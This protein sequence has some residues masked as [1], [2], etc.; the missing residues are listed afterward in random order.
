M[1]KTR[2]LVFYEQVASMRKIAYEIADSDGGDIRDDVQELLR[3]IYLFEEGKLG[4]VFAYDDFIALCDGRRGQFYRVPS[5]MDE[6]SRTP[7][8]S[9]FLAADKISVRVYNCIRKTN[10]RIIADVTA[11]SA[12]EWLKVK[13]FGRKSDP[14]SM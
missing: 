6:L 9:S 10:C 12:D 13:S 7:I 1:A 4:L 3:A 11:K 8:D 14:S 5:E 2:N